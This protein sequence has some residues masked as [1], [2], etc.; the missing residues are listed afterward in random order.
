MQSYFLEMHNVI[1]TIMRAKNDSRHSSASDDLA[2]CTSKLYYLNEIA[3]HCYEYGILYD[4]EKHYKRTNSGNI[5]WVK[6]IHKTIPQYNKNNFIH[7]SFI[8]KKKNDNTSLLSKIVAKILESETVKYPYHNAWIE[9]F[10]AQL[11]KECIYRRTL[12]D[13][14]DAK[15][16]CFNYIE[17]FY[18]AIR[19]QKTLGY[20]S[21][22]EFEAQSNDLKTNNIKLF[23]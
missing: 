23:A 17:G 18:N 2:V 4:D 14:R 5:D 21:P 3:N 11:K 8:V 16:T 1:T 15:L 13:V 6:T 9:S 10:H 22:N 20:I 12:K 19:T 7:D